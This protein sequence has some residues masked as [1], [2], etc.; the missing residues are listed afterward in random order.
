VGA[1]PLEKLKRREE[2]TAFIDEPRVPRF[3]KRADFFARTIFGDMGKEMQNNAKGGY[4][5]QKSAIGHCARRALGA[6]VAL[7][8]ALR[9]R[10]R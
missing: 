7:A 8:D 4:Y 9:K 5:V 1:Y 10:L 6:L 2:P 3:P